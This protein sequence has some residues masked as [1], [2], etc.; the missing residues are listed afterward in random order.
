MLV[1]DITSGVARI[2]SVA[3][4]QERRIVLIRLREVRKKFFAFIFQLPGWVLVAPLR[5]AGKPGT[6]QNWLFSC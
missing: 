5:L 6:V 4:A 2:L 1:T 3:R